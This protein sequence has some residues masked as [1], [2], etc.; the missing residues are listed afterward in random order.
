[1]GYRVGRVYVLEFEGTGMEGAVV[2]VA[3][4]SIDTIESISEMTDEQLHKTF[5]EHL[6]EWNLEARDGSALPMTVEAA[7]AE[8]EPEEL[9]LIIKEWYR[10]A[11]GA[12]APLDT[13]VTKTLSTSSDAGAP[14]QEMESL[15]LSIP[16]ETS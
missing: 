14:S 7:R 4:P 10:A 6:R 15:E 13:R 5:F 2:K 16:M 8:M 11:R 1:M 3:S 12:T 9:K